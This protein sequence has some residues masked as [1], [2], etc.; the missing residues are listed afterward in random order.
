ME[1]STGDIAI[2]RSPNGWSLVA[3]V[4][5]LYPQLIAH[6]RHL[7]LDQAP[8]Y[9]RVQN[10]VGHQL[11]KHQLADLKPFVT[12]G[13]A[14]KNLAQQATSHGYGLRLT[15]QPPGTRPRHGA[16]VASLYVCVDHPPPPPLLSLRHLARTLDDTSER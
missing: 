4:V 14:S 12:D 10:R 6:W 15:R 5:Y 16:A 7:N 1:A 2:S 13:G 8:G 9:P 3:G 11:R